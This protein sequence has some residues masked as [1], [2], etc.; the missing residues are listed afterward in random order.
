MLR[1][2]SRPD[3]ERFLDFIR[4]SDFAEPGFQRRPAMQQLPSR[5][6]GN[7]PW[8]LE[9]TAEP[10]GFN[11]L[12]RLF[13]FGIDQ[14]VERVLAAMPRPVLNFALASG[15]AS[16]V[17][18]RIV[19][20]VM[21]T[22]T[23]GWVIAADPVYRM[24]P[25]AAPDIILWPNQSTRVIQKF[26]LREPCG[27]TLDFG[28]GCGVVAVLAS[29][30]SGRVVATD[31][32]PRTEEFVNFNCWLNSVENVEC[33]IGDGFDTVAGIAFDRILANPPFFIVPSSGVLYCEN[34]LELDGFCR[35]V[36]RQGAGRL[37]EGGYLQMTF[38]WAQ[39]AGQPWQERLA[40]WVDSTGCDAWVLRTYT[41]EAAEYAHE[42]SSSQYADLPEAATAR[43][44]SCMAY[45]H[46]RQVKEIHGGLMVL[47][48]RSGPNWVRFE[49]GRLA[50]AGEPFAHLVREI[51]ETQDVL[52]S[53]PGDAALLEL[54]PRLSPQGG[55]E[56]Q[57]QVEDG[58]WVTT[59][60]KLGLAH[61]LPASL[62]IEPQVAD[63]LA[64]C[65]GSRTLAE[66]AGDVAA[67]VKAPLDVVRQQ[68]C[69]VVRRLAERRF[70][71]FVRSS[72]AAS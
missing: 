3:A 1:A 38:E 35:Q 11:I 49:E 65:D 67:V 47:R 32:N 70:V 72:G 29:R 68:C 28:A 50:I 30:F 44:Q 34:P 61:S 56:Q 57:L 23:E 54:R 52:Q 7:L 63:F 9:A 64:R 21:L 71:S 19:P 12:A 42:R 48:R 26:A 66:L 45:Y 25:E 4:C 31:L 53:R 62:T 51:F 6:A 16:A 2:T 37:N 60:F 36:V 59:S 39:I 20:L 22:P 14:P 55:I 13:V 69:A 24:Q 5:H 18:D 8:L 43:Y 40:E 27:V 46:E 17:D 41:A 33:R 58:R 10:T 15:L